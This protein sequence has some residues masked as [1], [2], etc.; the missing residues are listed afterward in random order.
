MAQGIL[1][2]RIELT[3]A[4]DEVTAYAGL[5]LVVEAL[6]VLVP[7][8]LYK[9][10]AKALGYKS[11]KVVRRHHESLMLLIVAGGDCIDDLATLRADPGLSSLLR[12]KITSPTQAKDFMYRLHQ[13]QDGAALTEQDDAR[14]SVQGGAQLRAEGPGLVLLDEVVRE[15]VRQV[16]IDTPRHRATLDVDATLIESHKAEAL[17][18]YKGFDGYQPQMAWW[19]EHG[20]WLLDQFRDGNVPAEFEARAFLQQAFGRLPECV[21][22]RRLR[23]DS[24]LYNEAALSWA[25]S[26]DIQFVVSADMSREL[27]KAVEALHD[28]DWAPY[29]SLKD[30]QSQHEERQWAEVL[31][32]VPDWK[33]NR[34]KGG[35]PFRYIA[36]RVRSKQTDLL[37]PEEERWRHFAVVTNMNWKDGGRLL[38]WHR[39]KQGTVEFA[40]G[41]AKNDLAGGTMPF[42]RFGS[43]AAWWRLNIIAQGLL[44]FLKAVALPHDMAS[45]RP[46]AL[47]FRLFGVAGRLIR[48]GRQLV[49]KISEALPGARVLV[50]ARERLLAWLRQGRAAPPFPT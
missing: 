9:E 1:P 16:Q 26:K 19:A 40:H 8:R 10:L 47:R 48:H 3:P 45:L 4:C 17:K 38:R 11:W 29:H 35:E 50:A 42:G 18:T 21:T 7:R 24:A 25:D 14:L 39:E 5:S 28:S 32:F 2:Y 36:I 13:A 30:Q 49:L 31:D 27:R 41:V 34:R 23:A 33:R 43:N 37:V 20:L 12:F 6:R 22:D 15:I 44:T 46:K